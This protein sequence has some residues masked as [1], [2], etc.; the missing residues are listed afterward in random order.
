MKACARVIVRLGAVAFFI[1]GDH[2]RT[3]KAPVL[4]GELS[5]IYG[6]ERTAEARVV[7]G[8]K[9]AGEPV[10]WT[11][12]KIAWEEFMAMDIRHRSMLADASA[13]QV[14]SYQCMPPTEVLCT[15][16]L[17]TLEAICRLGEGGFS[18]VTLTR[19]MSSR[20]CTL[21]LTLF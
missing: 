6:T 15:I 13:R 12:D 7:A 17:E 21:S 10:L 18:T 1:N 5:V 11:L 20:S 16:R 2:K 4:F 19:D 14:E 9:G 3:L 8:S